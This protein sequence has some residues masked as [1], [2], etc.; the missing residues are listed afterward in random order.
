METKEI[1]NQTYSNYEDAQDFDR[2][3]CE[4]LEDNG[5]IGEWTGKT[6]HVVVTITDEEE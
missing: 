1:F 5:L 4:L 3:I 6:V 2:D